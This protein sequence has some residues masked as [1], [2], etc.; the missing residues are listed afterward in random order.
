MTCAISTSAAFTK[1]DMLNNPYFQ[2]KPGE[3][4]VPT[5]SP[6]LK[7][8]PLTSSDPLEVARL[9]QVFEDLLQQPPEGFEFVEDG[10]DADTISLPED[11]DDVF[12]VLGTDADHPLGY[13]SGRV[14]SAFENGTIRSAF[15]TADV[16]PRQP[17]D[18]LAFNSGLISDRDGRQLSATCFSEAIGYRN[19]T[20]SGNLLSIGFLEVF[21]RDCGLGT[22]FLRLIQSSGYEMIELTAIDDR[23]GKF[24]ERNG[25]VRTGIYEDGEAPL[26]VWNNPAFHLHTNRV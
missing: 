19:Y 10:A 18:F 6:N 21:R 3:D 5:R 24:F 16:G 13:I 1:G 17:H 4:F 8:F 2:R 12:Y 14:T 20:G 9:R 25:F 11:P 23:R 26:M 15:R 22:D 7:I